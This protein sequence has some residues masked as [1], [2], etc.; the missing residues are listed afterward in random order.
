LGIHQYTFLTISRSGLL[1]MKN[2]RDKSVEKIKT[3]YV[4]CVPENLT[5]YDIMWKNVVDS[6]RP[7]MIICG[8]FI[9]CWITKATNTHSDYVTLIDFPH[10]KWLNERA[11]L[12][13]YTHIACLV[14]IQSANIIRHWRFFRTLV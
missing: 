6:N 8:M 11:S 9:E 5:V 12:L 13:R 3:N 7:H 10:Q 14:V 4:Q 2:V 1:I